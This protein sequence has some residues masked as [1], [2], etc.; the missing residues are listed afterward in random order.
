[1]Q[2]LNVGRL[3]VVRKDS[4]FVEFPSALVAERPPTDGPRLLAQESSYLR[5]RIESSWAEVSHLDPQRYG[6]SCPNVP[7]K[8]RAIQTRNSG[9]QCFKIGVF[10][11]LLRPSRRMS[12]NVQMF[13]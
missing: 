6:Y 10:L 7:R 2:G 4:R 8:P 11:E 5:Y 1:R 12:A 13:P 3:R 9:A